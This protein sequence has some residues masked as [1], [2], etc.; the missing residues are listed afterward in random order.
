MSLRRA[1]KTASKSLRLRLLLCWRLLVEAEIKEFDHEV[2]YAARD[3]PRPHDQEIAHA[4][5]LRASFIRTEIDSKLL[6]LWPSSTLPLL[7]QR[8]ITNCDLTRSVRGQNQGCCLRLNHVYLS[9][10]RARLNHKQRI[11][12][13]I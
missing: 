4:V 8:L 9:H 13:P 5:V 2:A 3:D 11:G 12:C 7:H 6:S 1:P 10:L